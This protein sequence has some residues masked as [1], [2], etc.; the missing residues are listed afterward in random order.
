MR[1]P[2]APSK[3]QV[4]NKKITPLL[5][6]L[7]AGTQTDKEKKSRGIEK[8]IWAQEGSVKIK[9]DKEEFE[10]SAG[11]SFYF[12]ASYPHQIINSSSKPAKIFVA[13]SPAEI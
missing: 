11:D 13:V 4:S 2:P 1:E 8:F 10:L 7:G 9:V 12:D 3:Q 5:I 6:E